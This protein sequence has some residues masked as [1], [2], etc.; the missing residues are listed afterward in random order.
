MAGTVKAKASDGVSV[1]VT[2]LLEMNS[3]RSFSIYHLPF[4]IC[5]WVFTVRR[6]NEKTRIQAVTTKTQ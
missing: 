4:L 1:V 5:H 2:L 6:S 3:V